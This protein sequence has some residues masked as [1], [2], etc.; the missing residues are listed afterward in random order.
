M[1]TTT[2]AE[3]AK[4]NGR[5]V[6][7]WTRVANGVC[8]QCGGSGRFEVTEEMFTEARVSRAKNIAAIKRELDAYA[9]DDS[10]HAD[11]FYFLGDLIARADA[12][13]AE[14]ALAAYERLGGVRSNLERQVAWSAS[15]IGVRVT[16]VRKVA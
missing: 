9:A 7:S 4:C 11:A 10:A 3:C 5:G 8:F 12:D 2:K 14:R 13:V 6:L 15:R 16:N 1:K